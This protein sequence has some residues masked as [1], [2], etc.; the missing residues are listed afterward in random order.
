VK[1]MP[2]HPARLA[3]LISAA[4]FIAGCGG[5]PAGP[6]PAPSG[7]NDIVRAGDGLRLGSGWWPVEHQGSLT[8]RWVTNDAEV[9][10]CP[11]VNNRTV[12]MMIEPGPGV[13]SKPFTL[14][15]RG[16]RGDTLSTV[17]K[18]GQYIKIAVNPSAPAETFVL[19]AVSS[20][21]PTPHDPRHVLNFR[22]LSL[23]LGSAASDCKNEIVYDGSPIAIGARWYPYETFN[24]QSFRWV[25]NN[26]QVKLSAAQPRPFVFE[27]EVEP[28][29]SLGGAPLQIAVRSANGT[30]LAQ[31]ASATGRTYVVLRL[32]PEPNAAV[33]TLAVKSKNAKVSHERRTLNFRVFGLKIKP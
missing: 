29:P 21:I 22:A 13:R 27:A 15:V 2:S 23:V 18:P 28:G 1:R 10:A 33:L 24:G 14:R 31:S 19:H 3:S 16:N 17:A 6:T 12:A 26:A 4:L 11:D 8:F 7:A 32:P 25:N 30:T 9:T 20:N 5:P